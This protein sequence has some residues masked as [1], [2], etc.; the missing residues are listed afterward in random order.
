MK[1]GISM[2]PTD[3]AIHPAELAREVEGRGF[4]SLWMPGAYPHPGKQAHARARRRG[5]AGILL[6]HVRPVR[7]PYGRGYGHDAPPYRERHLPDHRARSHHYGK[8]DR[9]P[10]QPLGRPIHIRHWRGLERRGDGEPRDGFQEAVAHPARA[11]PRHEGD[12]DEGRGRI[13]RGI[14]Q[15]R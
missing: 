14:R 15:F 10:R 3:Y 8:G 5:P 13:S 7:R 1:F 2:F 6:A 9:E 11:R 12:M 4:E